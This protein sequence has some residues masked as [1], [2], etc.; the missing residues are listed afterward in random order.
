MLPQFYYAVVLA[1]LIMRFNWLYS[2][3][4]PG[5]LH[6]L[7]SSITSVFVTTMVTGCELVRR[8]MWGF[9]RVEKEHLDNTEVCLSPLVVALRG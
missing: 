5:H 4:P 6:F 2:L 9:F 8:T 3:I 1:D 7:H